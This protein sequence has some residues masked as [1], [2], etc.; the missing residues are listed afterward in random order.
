MNGTTVEVRTLRLEMEDEREAA[1][2]QT[3][4]GRRLADPEEGPRA[5]TEP[6]PAEAAPAVD[7]FG[8]RCDQPPRVPP[9]VSRPLPHHAEEVEELDLRDSTEARR[10]AKC[11][12]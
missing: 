4:S 3:R 6:A 11:H 7:E 9:A 2:V 12:R 10:E 5:A 1:P 8:N